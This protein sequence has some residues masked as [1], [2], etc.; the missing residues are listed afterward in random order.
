MF[1]GE[2][3]PSVTSLE[4]VLLPQ[5]PLLLAYSPAHHHDTV[6]NG[7]FIYLFIFNSVLRLC[8]TCASFGRAPA[9]VQLWLAFASLTESEDSRLAMCLPPS[10]SSGRRLVSPCT[11]AIQSGEKKKKIFS[12]TSLQHHR[13]LDS[14]S[15][16]LTRWRFAAG[17]LLGCFGC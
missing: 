10:L 3:S 14:I 8:D 12:L 4:T 16:C 5:P 17:P 13:S 7:S 6:A 1:Q 15:S 9:L 11:F 2:A